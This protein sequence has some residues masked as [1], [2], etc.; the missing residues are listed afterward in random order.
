M[1]L[2]SAVR[3]VRAATFSATCAGLA[4]AG[5]LAAG[6]KVAAP[7][8]TA[9]F[10]AMFVP[11]LPLTRRERS[12]GE[13]LPAVALC[14]IALHLLLSRCCSPHGTTAVQDAVPAAPSHGAAA[15]DADGSSGF[16]MLLMHAV[17]V[18]ITSWWLEQGEAALCALVRCVAAWALRT[19]VWLRTPAPHGA[20][21]PRPFFWQRHPVPARVLRHVMARRGPP[22][23]RVILV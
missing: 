5:H 11:A 16:G 22:A 13:I 10:V 9:G 17:A 6:G 4:A 12:I 18:L 14:E 15:H 1:E 19:L 3:L 8:L 23:R 2:W 21:P 7:L 20:A